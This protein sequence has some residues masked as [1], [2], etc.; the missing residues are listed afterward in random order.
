VEALSLPDLVASKK[1][2]R[3]KDWVMISRLLEASYVSGSGAQTPER[4]AFWLDELRTPELLVACAA[5]HPEEAARAAQKRR[6]TAAA[7]G[8][9]EEEIRAALA[10]EEAVERSLDREYWAPLRREL[11]EIR[12]SR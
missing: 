12:R 8:G 7:I 10:E 6:A 3:D 1:T 2:Q 5:S 9:R 4:V 11:E